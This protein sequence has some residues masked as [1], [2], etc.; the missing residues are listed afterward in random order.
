MGGAGSRLAPHRS[1]A[2]VPAIYD[3]LY[4][5]ALTAR[6]TRAASYYNT[7][8]AEPISVGQETAPACVHAHG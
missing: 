7:L 3:T 6:L 4:N 8:S 1:D 5:H 2:A